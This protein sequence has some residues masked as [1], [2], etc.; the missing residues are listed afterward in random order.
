[1][2]KLYY[3]VPTTDE[4]NA[5]QSVFGDQV[6]HV[7]GVDRRGAGWPE[8]AITT[9]VDTGDYWPTVW[10]AVSCH[11]TQLPGYSALKNLPEEHHRALWGSR[12]YYRA[13][14]TINGGRQVERDLFEGL[15]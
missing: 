1:V 12:G 2:L 8:W 14:S 5:Y 4:L 15:R 6:M 10:K 13:Y 7:D 11:Q 3:M 9:C